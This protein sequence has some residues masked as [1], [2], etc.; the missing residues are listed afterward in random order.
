LMG[1]MESWDMDGRMGCAGLACVDRNCLQAGWFRQAL[2][3]VK[4]P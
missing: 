1:L 3:A 4:N 2:R